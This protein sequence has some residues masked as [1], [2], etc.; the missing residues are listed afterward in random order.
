MSRDSPGDR[1]KCRIVKNS[2]FL[3]NFGTYLAH[4]KGP[5]PIVSQNDLQ[6]KSKGGDGAPFPRSAAPGARIFLGTVLHIGADSHL[7]AFLYMGAA[8]HIGAILNIGSC[9]HFG[10]SPDGSAALHMGTNPYPSRIPEAPE[11]SRRE[12]EPTPTNPPPV[13]I[14]SKFFFLRPQFIKETPFFFKKK[15]ILKPM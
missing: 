9:M 13:S 12:A 3:E 5:L 4:K 10:T 14:V 2:N 15:I 6:K 7:G 8:S 1:S 11:A